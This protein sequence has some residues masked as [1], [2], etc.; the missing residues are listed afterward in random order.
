MTTNQNPGNFANRPVEDR[1]AAGIAGGK[2]EG[3]G[4]AAQHQQEAHERVEHGEVNTGGS[5]SGPR[6][7]AS[8]GGQ[9]QQQRVAEKGEAEDVL[10]AGQ[11][12]EEEEEG[13][14]GGG[15]G[16]KS[17]RGFAAMPREKVQEIA[18]M[19]G[20]ASKGGTSE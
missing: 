3:P 4:S 20:R 14:G 1:V 5:A 10:E 9:Q 16:G 7:A 2:N 15:G 18:R 11:D 12:Q 6:S 8:A 13:G 19:G 17:K